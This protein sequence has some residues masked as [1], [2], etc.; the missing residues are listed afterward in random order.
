MH[1]VQKAFLQS[2]H[3]VCHATQSQFTRREKSA[4]SFRKHELV[5]VLQCLE[6]LSR[7]LINPKRRSRHLKGLF[8]SAAFSAMVRSLMKYLYTGHTSSAPLLLKSISYPSG[9]FEAKHRCDTN[10]NASSFSAFF[11][12]FAANISIHTHTRTHM[13]EREEKDLP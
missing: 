8:V 7:M 2:L 12:S 13:R 9:S 1:K 4:K 5:P 3:S 10:S 6:G 11:F